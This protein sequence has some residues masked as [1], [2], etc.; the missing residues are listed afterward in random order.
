MKTSQKSLVLNEFRHGISV[1]PVGDIIEFRGRQILPG[2]ILLLRG[3]GIISL[4]HPLNSTLEVIVWWAVI[5][6]ILKGI[7]EHFSEEK[8]IVDG[9]IRVFYKNSFF[10]KNLSLKTL[11]GKAN[12]FACINGILKIFT[13]VRKT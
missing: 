2:D 4:G 12:K 13:L 1:L 3:G 8:T 9:V 10:I 7:W 6:I 5:I 11:Q